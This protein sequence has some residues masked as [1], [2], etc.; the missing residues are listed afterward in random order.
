MKFTKYVACIVLFNPHMVT[1][2]SRYPFYRCGN[3][4]REMK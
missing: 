1:N 4:F 3:R 2:F